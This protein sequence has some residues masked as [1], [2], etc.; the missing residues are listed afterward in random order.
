MASTEGEE[1][2]AGGRDGGEM[3]KPEDYEYMHLLCEPGYRPERKQDDIKPVRGIFFACLI[4]GSLLYML[5]M[6]WKAVR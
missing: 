2:F 5:A 4:G 1:S 3:R 6:I